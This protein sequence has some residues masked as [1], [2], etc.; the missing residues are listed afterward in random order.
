MKYLYKTQDEHFARLGILDPPCKFN[1]GPPG[2]NITDI[3][4][5]LCETNKYHLG[6]GGRTKSWKPR[7]ILPPSVIPRNQDERFSAPRFA[8]TPV[9]TPV[10]SEQ[11]DPFDMVSAR[12]VSPQPYAQYQPEYSP[13]SD[14][15]MDRV[16]EPERP[17]T[18]LW[19]EGYENDDTEY[20]IS[21]IYR[22]RLGSDGWEFKVQ[23]VGWG[24]DH[25]T[26]LPESAFGHA[27]EILKAWRR[28]NPRSRDKTDKK[29]AKKVVS[30]ITKGRFSTPVPSHRRERKGEG[31]TK[32]RRSAPEQI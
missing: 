30:R 2:V 3:E 20:E 6:R 10:L 8:T 1:D 14:I 21:H 31:I 16:V 19:T 7:D 15:D 27:K 4:H 29:R 22:E 12:E 11:E 25:D 28:R 18:P 32:R 13:L 26:W 24:S 23:W 17:P 5:S 9:E